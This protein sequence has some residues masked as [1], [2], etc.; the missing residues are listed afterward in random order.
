MSLRERKKQ[1]TQQAILEAAKSLIER[2]GF[3]S[4]TTRLIAEAADISYQTLYN[5]FPSKN[6]ILIELLKEKLVGSEESYKQ[7]IRTF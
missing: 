6:D 1:K 7:I 5:Y 4:V 3:E 2:E